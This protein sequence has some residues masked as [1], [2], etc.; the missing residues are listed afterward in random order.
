MTRADGG[1]AVRCARGDVRGFM[2]YLIR[3]SA[4]AR[5]GRARGLGAWMG[6]LHF[7]RRHHELARAS[8]RRHEARTLA[9]TVG[10]RS[11]YLDLI[12]R[13]RTASFTAAPRAY[14]PMNDRT[15]SPQFAR[16]T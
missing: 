5:G 10:L 1:V 2:F 12:L 14:A 13:A 16:A 6:R 3:A 9:E 15:E 11:G 7:P 4:G 8:L